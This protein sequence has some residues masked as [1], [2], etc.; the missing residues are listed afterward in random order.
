MRELEV[1]DRQRSNLQVLITAGTVWAR[2][3][4]LLGGRGTVSLASN[5]HAAIAHDGLIGAEQRAD[6]TFVCWTRAGTVQLIDA[7]GASLGPLEPGH[8]A[9]ISTRG[10]PMTE[11]FSV[12]RSTVEIAARGPVWPLVVMPDGV[13]L[14][15]FVDPG[16]EVNQV[17]G[18]LTARRDEVRVVEVP[19]GVPGPYRVLSPASRTGST[20]SPSPAGSGGGRSSSGSGRG[21][22]RAGSAWR[23]AWSRTSTRA[24]LRGQRGGDAHWNVSPMRPARGPAPGFVLLSPSSWKR[25]R[26]GSRLL[27]LGDPHA[28]PV[29]PG[30]LV[31]ELP[32]PAAVQRDGAVVRRR[33]GELLEE[34]HGLLPAA[35]W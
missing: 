23:A 12:H 22:S 29:A 27:R 4:N 28:V 14:A 3:A 8:K 6:G 20:W 31:E 7:S 35:L 26:A 17:F 10:R 24:R 1:G 32:G 11:E 33:R 19:G 16:I 9:T 5:T 30:G 13:R 18:S 25:R 21:P 15:G 2:I 34:R